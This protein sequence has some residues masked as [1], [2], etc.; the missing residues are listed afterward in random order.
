MSDKH[1]LIGKIL[2]D[3]YQ[4]T[5]FLGKGG[6]G[7]VFVAQQQSLN[8]QV[9][10]KLL[11]ALDLTSEEM[12]RFE[13][14]IAAMA[15][16]SHPNIVTIH[17]RGK[18]G[19]PPTLFYIMELLEGG[20]LRGYLQKFGKMPPGL[21][22]HLIRPVGEALAF[23]HEQGC[24]HRDIKPDNLLFT[25]NYR[26]LKVADFGIAKLST[27]VGITNAQSMVGTIL[28]AA[29]EQMKWFE[30]E[31]DTKDAELEIDQRVDQ[32]A[33]GVVLYEM[34]SGQLP[35]KARNLMEMIKALS[36]DPLPISDVAGYKVPRCLDWLIA[37][38][39]A[40]AREN[41]FNDDETLLDAFASV[42][43]E[44]TT[45]V[46]TRMFSLQQSQDNFSAVPPPSAFSLPSTGEKQL[47][48]SME[49]M[50]CIPSPTRQNPY[51]TVALVTLV[52][53]LLAIIPVLWGLMASSKEYTD[54][55]SKPPVDI[56]P[57]V[58]LR[59]VPIYEPPPPAN[60]PK[61][62]VI[63][64]SQ[65]GLRTV[66][67]QEQIEP[68]SYQLSVILPGYLCQEHGKTIEV[69]PGNLFHLSLTLT[70][71]PRKIS[72][73]IVN[74]NNG[75]AVSPLVFQID[76]QSILGNKFRP[77]ERR[78]YALFDNYQEIDAPVWIPP[79]EDTFQHEM[80]LVPL[81]DVLFSFDVTLN[82]N[83]GTPY[84]LEI[85]VD[86]RQQPAVHLQYQTRGEEIHGRMRIAPAAKEILIRLGFYYCI[87]P[88][89]Q[90]YLIHSLENLDIGLLLNHLAQVQERK[91]LLEWL[92]Q[93]LKKDQ[94]KLNRLT[95][96]AQERL[97]R[98][99][100]SKATPDDMNEMDSSLWQMRR[101]LKSEETEE[102]KAFT[103]SSSE[104]SKLN[105]NEKANL[106]QTFINKYPQGV[107]AKQAQS[108]GDYYRDVAKYEL[109]FRESL[110]DCILSLG[111]K[112]TL[113]HWESKL[114][115]EDIA[116]IRKKAA[117]YVKKLGCSQSL[118][119]MLKNR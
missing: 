105:F 70:A 44:L 97:Y 52:A 119:E 66:Q 76:K 101:L 41:R 18:Y 39:I 14:E 60:Y 11:P 22:L 37:T 36:Q 96:D 9:A 6:M 88:V 54:T 75:E 115:A 73:R 53:L 5:S 8:R 98:F 95:P 10:I 106:W 4:I 63:M 112:R 86:G 38:M 116:Q 111:E 13:C 32:Y 79:G 7:S 17:H 56:T 85:Y 59:I 57:R 118:D 108:L 21:A 113:Q 23:A 2:A 74:T 83:D 48:Q 87:V 77:G 26:S 47:M 61:L 24:I 84:E 69:R 93:L 107:Y 117:D 72:P 99:L 31:G 80:A 20:S 114:S 46:S 82:K 89:E 29:P 19:D 62:R 91:L 25:R 35:Y 64:M 109:L 27:G 40:K 103:A 49:T 104:A 55:P 12:Q 67:L 15:T 30:G 45:S 28:Y 58:S 65:R 43:L 3:D 100:V 42:E 68:G 90:L 1:P 78:L 51:K 94:K 102:Y 71:V 50:S 33:L 34:I 92:E 110:R 81:R 16:L